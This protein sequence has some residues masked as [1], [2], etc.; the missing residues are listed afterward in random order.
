MADNKSNI[1]I[2]IF[3]DDIV[4]SSTSE[5]D[6]IKLLVLYVQLLFESMVIKL[7]A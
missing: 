7:D 2:T 5:S 6:L 3:M 1:N 4:I